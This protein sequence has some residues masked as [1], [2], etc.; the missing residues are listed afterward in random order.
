MSISKEFLKAQLLDELNNCEEEEDLYQKEFKSTKR[1]DFQEIEYTL[2]YK[3]LFEKV[4]DEKEFNANTFVKG[5]FTQHRFMFER[6]LDKE[7]GDKKTL[8]RFRQFACDK[9]VVVNVVQDF[10]K[11]KQEEKDEIKETG[12][13]ST[14]S[15]T[16]TDKVMEDINCSFTDDSG[17]YSS[18]DL[19]A[20]KKGVY[21][22]GNLAAS[23]KA[24]DIFP[25]IGEA[26]LRFLKREITDD[27]LE[28]IPISSYCADR[29]AHYWRLTYNTILKN[30]ARLVASREDDPVKRQERINSVISSWNSM[31][32]RIPPLLV[33][34]CAKNAVSSTDDGASVVGSDATCTTIISADDDVE[35]VVID[36]SDIMLLLNDDDNND[37][38]ND[39]VISDDVINVS[40]ATADK[41]KKE[42]AKGKV[43]S[44]QGYSKEE[45]QKW[46][47]AKINDGTFPDHRYLL[48]SI[49]SK[50]KQVRRLPKQE[51]AT[52]TSLDDESHCDQLETFPASNV[53]HYP[54]NEKESLSNRAFSMLEVAI[55]SGNKLDQK[56]MQQLISIALDQEQQQK[57]RNTANA[58]SKKKNSKSRK[59]AESASSASTATAATTESA[60]TTNNATDVTTSAA[61]AD[62]TASTTKSS[63]RGSTKKRKA[64]NEAAA[65][66]TPIVTKKRNA[67]SET[68]A[69]GT[70]SA[71][72]F[73][74]VT[75]G[76]TVRLHDNKRGD[77]YAL[78]DV[79]YRDKD[80]IYL[81][82]Q[83]LTVRPIIIKKSNWNRIKENN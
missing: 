30:A 55:K 27:D 78:M 22:K 36:D 21:R 39:G 28:N 29:R 73:S 58:S 2:D 57:G 9:E 23:K 77:T 62:T 76:A 43:G 67:G 50:A 47:L 69:S 14:I 65:G 54:G 6:V 79:T 37:D 66:G 5:P 72:T 82:E 45:S 33:G 16:M 35:T 13:N 63:K 3:K 70:T 4:M 7:S 75:V 56:E 71:D 74:F 80:Q 8:T 10:V 32:A 42:K 81:C 41:A 25:T 17:F 48:K 53:M 83:G 64:G 49:I 59:G 24:N 61:T 26:P 20:S 52:S 51:K 60:S 68:A 18:K 44:L 1:L 15:K 12:K 34:K 11:L 31:N 38:N 40:D 19:S 46:V